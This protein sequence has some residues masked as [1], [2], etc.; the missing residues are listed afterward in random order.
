MGTILQYSGCIRLSWCLVAG[1]GVGVAWAEPHASD[2]VRYAVDMRYVEP[3][4][5]GASSTATQEADSADDGG[6]P[7]RHP[8]DRWDLRG[9]AYL[10]YM[11]PYAHAYGGRYRLRQWGPNGPLMGV[12]GRG[13]DGPWIDDDYR[14]WRYWYKWRTS[15]RRTRR[16]LQGHEE[17]V[18]R[19]VRLF[20][21]GRYEEARSAFLLA[22]DMNH[23]DPASRLHAANACFALQRYDRA[24]HWLEEAFHL[25]PRLSHLPLDPRRDYG[26]QEDFNAHLKAV[27]SAVSLFPR[28]H[29]PKIVLAYVLYY[30]GDRDEAHEMLSRVNSETK[31]NGRSKREHL[32]TT[33][34]SASDPGKYAAVRPKD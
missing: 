26:R 32:I 4:A 3:P 6:L 23:G 33:L 21:E 22:A 8:Y 10:P 30:T 7:G 2:D 34:L 17:M 18:N 9:Y 11:G 31:G 29:G 1:F 27:R 15:K 14:E 5:D 25:E 24:T 12:P 28:E 19:G 13:Y 16:L 20:A